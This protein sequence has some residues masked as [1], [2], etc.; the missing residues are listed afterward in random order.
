MEINAIRTAGE[1][2]TFDPGAPGHS[3]LATCTVR[4]DNHANDIFLVRIID[5]FWLMEHLPL[6]GKRIRF[7]RTGS[8]GHLIAED[9]ELE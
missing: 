5:H 7:S 3:E 2:I 1:I 4:D 9:I 8:S 6:V